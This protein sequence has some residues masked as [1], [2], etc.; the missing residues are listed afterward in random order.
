MEA[1]RVR[2]EPAGKGCGTSSESEVEAL[3]DCVQVSKV[4]QKKAFVALKDAGV[5]KKVPNNAKEEG[6]SS[7]TDSTS[8]SEVAGSAVKKR[9]TKGKK[10]EPAC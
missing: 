7:Y 8:G 5:G 2:K 6:Q 4:N 1:V 9:G 10:G 3:D